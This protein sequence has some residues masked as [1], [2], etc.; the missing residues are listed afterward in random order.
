MTDMTRSKIAIAAVYLSFALL[1]VA[2]GRFL[3]RERATKRDVILD[4]VSALAVPLIIIPVI[5]GLAPALT[6]W[7]LP[8]SQ[9]ALAWLPW[10]AKF[11]ALLV[12]DD[13]TQY[14]WHRLS[15]SSAL[16]PLH[17][18]HHSAGY[19][20]IRIVYRN[21]LIYYAMMPGLW[22]SGALIYFGMA[23]VYVVY[24]ALKMSVIIA[25]HSSVAWDEP[26]YRNRFTAPLMW[27]VERVI[28]TPSTHAAHHGLYADD[29]VTHYHGNYGNFL[30]LWDV[31]LGT[32]HITRRRPQDYGI[33]G[34]EPVALHRELLWPTPIHPIAS[35]P[36][37]TSP[38]EPDAPAAQEGARPL[39]VQEKRS[40]SSPSSG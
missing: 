38:G 27:I 3:H 10:W 30:F 1:E 33:E 20:S 31:L 15:H 34:L 6:R 11:A 5:L 25:A 24:A 26:L 7:L 23:E 13:L 19:M 2:L 18:A 17:R 39:E 12:F 16:Y 37:A 40:R 22:L 21:N 35:S 8:G 14:L 32:A 28:S 9:G 4:A 29:G 36:L